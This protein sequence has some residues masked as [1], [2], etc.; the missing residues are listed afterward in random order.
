[1]ER[2][3]KLGE[4]EEATE[5]MKLQAEVYAQS[6]HHLMNKYKN[7]KWY[8]FWSFYLDDRARFFNPGF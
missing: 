6:A 7:K 8:Q 2:G 5:R 1:M 4:T 3:E